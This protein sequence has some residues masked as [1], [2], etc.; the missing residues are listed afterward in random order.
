MRILARFRGRHKIHDLL[1]RTR[2]LA[3]KRLEDIRERSKR[4]IETL[5]KGVRENVKRDTERARAFVE[6]ARERQLFSLKI[7]DIFFK[8]DTIRTYIV[9]LLTARGIIDISKLRDAVKYG[10]DRIRQINLAN[11][12]N[13]EKCVARYHVGPCNSYKYYVKLTYTTKNILKDL[14]ERFVVYVR[15]WISNAKLRDRLLNAIAFVIH[16][17]LRS[18]TKS[19]REDYNSEYLANTNSTLDDYDQLEIS[20]SDPTNTA[21]VY[22]LGFLLRHPTFIARS[23]A[24]KLGLA[25]YASD[26]HHC[27]VYAHRVEISRRKHYRGLDYQRYYDFIIYQDKERFRGI[28]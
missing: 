17:L 24:F 1:E 2:E 20:R 9:D 26:T 18:R 8:T 12:Y 25:E 28:K 16:A 5:S 19:R 4:L 21:R 7:D 10:L 3:R 6:R 14:V 27:S 22:S 23:L 11:L 15:N 13:L